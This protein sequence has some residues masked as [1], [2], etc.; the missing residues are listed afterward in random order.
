[1]WNSVSVTVGSLPITSRATQ[2][3]GRSQPSLR[4]LQARCDILSCTFDCMKILPCPLSCVQ[5]SEFFRG[6]KG[7]MNFMMFLLQRIMH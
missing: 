2:S 7:P 4:F 3:K 6:R 1:M 5:A